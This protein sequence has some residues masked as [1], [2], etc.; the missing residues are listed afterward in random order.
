MKMSVWSNLKSDWVRV[1]TF[2]YSD[3]INV[4]LNGE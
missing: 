2:R 4:K 1:I 3:L